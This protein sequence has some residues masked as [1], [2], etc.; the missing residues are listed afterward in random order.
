MQDYMSRG[1]FAFKSNSDEGTPA[2]LGILSPEE[3]WGS[4][5]VQ[6]FLHDQFLS[7]FW[8]IFSARFYCATFLRV[9]TDLHVGNYPSAHILRNNQLATHFRT[10]GGHH[11]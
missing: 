3:N 7:T 9:H 8:P 11:T 5:S 10:E 4:Y 1:G 6:S 2:N